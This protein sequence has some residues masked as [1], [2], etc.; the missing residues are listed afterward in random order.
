M[1]LILES[2]IF[3]SVSKQPCD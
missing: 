3:N 2:F 1:Q